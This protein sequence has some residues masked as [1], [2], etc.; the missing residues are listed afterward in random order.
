MPE[1]LSGAKNKGGRPKGEP[2]LARTVRFTVS[3]SPWEAYVYRQLTGRADLAEAARHA[4]LEQIEDAKER[5]SLRLSIAMKLGEDMDKLPRVV[6]YD[7]LS[8]AE[9]IVDEDPT[10]AEAQRWL[11]HAISESK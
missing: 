3:L 11:A 1:K 7:L 4:M 9:G 6:A 8:E 2:G 5:L 10:S